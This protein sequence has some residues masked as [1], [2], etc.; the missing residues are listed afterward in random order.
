MRIVRVFN[1]CFNDFEH[2]VDEFLAK[3]KALDL[4]KWY[5]NLKLS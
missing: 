1:R 2:R 5:E 4:T 3:L